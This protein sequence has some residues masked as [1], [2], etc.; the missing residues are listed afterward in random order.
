MCSAIDKLDKHSWS[1]VRKEL[2]E[3]KNIAPEIA[4]RIKHYINLKG[5]ISSF[6]YSID[7]K[8]KISSFHFNNVLRTMTINNF[9]H[10]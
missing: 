8:G 1:E 10:C 9:F 5:K 3:E 7:F 2:V 4:D 6:N